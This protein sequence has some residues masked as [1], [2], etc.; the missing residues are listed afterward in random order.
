MVLDSSPAARTTAATFE[1]LTKEEVIELKEMYENLSDAHFNFEKLDMSPLIKKL[2]EN[3]QSLKD[4]LSKPTNTAR[5]LVQYIQ[6][7]S[8]IKEFTRAGRIDDWKADLAA[9]WKI[10]NLF[11]ACVHKYLC[12]AVSTKYDR[13][14][15]WVSLALPAVYK[16]KF[17]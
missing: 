15:N 17:P 8:I 12:H 14:R 13:T 2:Q 5:L 1:V 9:M 11:A 6:Y 4:V 10:R 3:S 16:P 7:M